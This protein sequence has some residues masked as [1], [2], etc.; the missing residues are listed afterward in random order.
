MQTA[1]GKVAEAFCKSEMHDFLRY[2]VHPL[3]ELCISRRAQR[4]AQMHNPPLYA[5]GGQ[6]VTFS[7]L[8]QHWKGALLAAYN[9]LDKGAWF[10][11]PNVPNNC[12]EPTQQP[13]FLSYDNHPSHSLW[14]NLK[15]KVHLSRDVLPLS[16]LQIIRICPKGHDIHQL[17][18]HGIGAI[19]GYV[20]RHLKDAAEHG[21][22]LE[23]D[24]VWDIVRDGTSV[25]NAKSW[26][27][28]LV[29]LGHALRIIAADSDQVVRFSYPGDTK[30][31]VLGRAGNYAPMFVS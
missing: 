26:D 15:K 1:D 24:V 17:P 3:A 31:E 30:R 25:F 18:E 10:A 4:E 9:G 7:G 23:T 2:F 29:R 27:K 11:H 5:C 16:L 6:M 20:A 8:L 22:P 21:E 14:V 13:Y 19:K 12:Y 28:N